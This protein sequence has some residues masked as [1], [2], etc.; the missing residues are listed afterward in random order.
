MGKIIVSYDVMM[1]EDH[2]E[3]LQFLLDDHDQLIENI[4]ENKIV[5]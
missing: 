4:L 3:T 1:V 2:K 5:V